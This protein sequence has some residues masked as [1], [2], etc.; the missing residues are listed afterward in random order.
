MQVRRRSGGF[1]LVA[2]LLLTCVLSLLVAHMASGALTELELARARARRAK[3]TAAVESGLSLA[4]LMVAA[5]ARE[6]STGA[7]EPWAGGPVRLNPGNASVT[8]HVEDENGR[9]SVPHL[10][11]AGN[12]D[13]PRELRKHLQR[14]AQES[15]DAFELDEDEIFRWIVAH[16]FQLDLP[17]KLR[18]EPLFSVERSSPGADRAPRPGDFL[19]V[20]T[21]GTL[22]V[23]T[24][25]RECLEFLWGETGERFIEAVVSRREDE[26]FQHSEELFA[27]PG[28][29]RLLRS[30]PGVRLTTRGT[31]F[32]IELEAVAG[33]S[34]LCEE[35]IVSADQPGVPV[36]YRR[37]IPSTSISGE[38]REM[39]VRAFVAALE[40]E[41][42]EDR[43]AR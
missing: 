25:P 42:E 40:S 11:R 21:D 3:L 27:L 41:A 43:N 1:V 13:T 31:V 6:K 33:P 36:I 34:R 12:A 20:W 23:N 10:I 4:R 32:R 29:A 19:T 38:P 22:N 5:R 8:F 28:S 18:G 24:A 30:T 14:F 16:Q 17:E 37:L 15:A 39:D 2:V 26:P 9:I 35:A 7:P